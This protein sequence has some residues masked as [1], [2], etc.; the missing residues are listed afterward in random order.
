ML[1]ALHE[2]VSWYDELG[3]QSAVATAATEILAALMRSGRV[4]WGIRKCASRCALLGKVSRSL[5]QQ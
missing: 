4:T 1:P 3:V 2:H 5:L